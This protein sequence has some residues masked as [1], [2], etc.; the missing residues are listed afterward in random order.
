MPGLC[1]IIGEALLTP[2]LNETHNVKVYFKRESLPFLAVFWQPAHKDLMNPFR[3]L[4]DAFKRPQPPLPES[5][6][7]GASLTLEEYQSL[8]PHMSVHEGDIEVVFC[9]PNLAAQF[10]VDTL[11]SKEPDTIEWIRGFAPGEVL[12]DI[13]ANV[14]MYTIWAAKTR[15]VRVF[16]FEPESQNYA[17]L[18]RNIIRNGL[19]EQVTG[20]CLALSDESA[21][22]RLYLSDFYAGGSCHTFGEQLDHRLEQRHS[23]YS[24]GSVSCTLDKLVADGVVPLPDHIKID[25]DGLEHKVLH[26]C[27]ATLKNPKLK[28]V[29]VE[30]NTNL[31]LH[32]NIIQEMRTLGFGFSEA[33]VSSALRSEGAF[34]GVGNHIFRR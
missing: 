33:Q 15:G 5:P 34:A 27:A 12:V 22:S 10:R 23:R 30:I 1:G 25:V 32:R 9:T 31:E 8:D 26:G 13:G 4:F 3:M 20:Y 14:G 19:S 28:S 16:A 17:L 18:Y 21:C 7:P 2:E 29:L 24:Q 11:R 6:P